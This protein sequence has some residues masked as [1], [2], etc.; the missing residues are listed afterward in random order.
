MNNCPKCSAPFE[1]GTKFCPKCGCDLEETFIINPVCPVCHKTYPAGSAFCNADGTKLVSPE[2]LIPKCVI[3]GTQYSA[4]TKFCPKDGGAVVPEVLKYATIGSTNVCAGVY[5]NKAS[6]VSRFV[7]S[8]LD[9]I[10]SVCLYIPAG[11]ALLLGIANIYDVI[12]D[13]Y[14]SY[15]SSDY[16]DYILPIFFFLMAFILQFIPILYVLTKD[17]LGD[18]QSWGKKAMGIKVI[19][20]SDNSNCTKG[21]S[22]LR[23]LIGWLVYIIPVVGWIVEPVMIIVTSDGRRVADRVAGTM[24]VNVNTNEINKK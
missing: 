23:T 3:C 14:N 4:D 15:G 6:L 2:K 21:I 22:A 17:G 19:N 20:V 13:S 12:F 5:L 8:I 9:S 1:N 7:A 24:V 11:I 10:I 16:S 18:G